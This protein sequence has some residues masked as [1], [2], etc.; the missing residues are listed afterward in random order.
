MVD[1]DVRIAVLL[2]DGF[3]DDELRTLMDTFEQAGVRLTLLS[4]FAE[5]AY[6][7]R[8]GRLTLTSRTRPAR[9]AR[10]CLPPS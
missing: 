8:H 9:Y 10:P 2:E 6:S 7:G 5:R 3:E 1:D 4:P